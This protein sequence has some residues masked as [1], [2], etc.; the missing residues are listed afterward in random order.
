MG[1]YLAMKSCLEKNNLHYFT[2]SP[3]SKRPIEAIIHHL[4][5]DMP[6]EDIS[7][8]LEDLGF[9]I[10]NVRQMMPTRTAPNV[11]TSGTPPSVSCYLIK[12]SKI[13]RDIQAE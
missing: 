3:N 8:G 10:I 12:K 13:S 7:S 11:Q 6:V 2:F 1:D 4:P 9:N 5:P